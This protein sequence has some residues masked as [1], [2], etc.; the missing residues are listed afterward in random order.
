MAGARAAA[1]RSRADAACAAAVDAARAAAAEVAQPGAVG[2]HLAAEA[3]GERVVTHTF[4][5][6]SKAYRGWHWAVTVARVARAK[7][8]TVCEVELLAGPEALIAPAHVPWQERLAPG[9]LG[10]GDVLSRVDDDARLEAG[11]EATGDTD[12]DQLAQWELGLG[13]RRVLSRNGRDEAAIRWRDGAFGPRAAMA[14]AAEE[15]CSTC[16]YMIPAPGALRPAFG[17][18][19]NVWS[20]ADGRVVSLDYGCGAHSE[21]D[22]DT[23]HQPLP[24]P[25]LDDHEVESVTLRPHPAGHTPTEDT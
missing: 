14:D 16:G 19:A 2:E 9:D 25:V 4:A 21:S 7:S 11:F 5:C 18:C 8:V 17:L 3:M 6:L 24:E 12:V 22:Q 1:T 10:P 20:P 15:R 13:R 23:Q